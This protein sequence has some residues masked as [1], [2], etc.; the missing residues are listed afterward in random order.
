MTAQLQ[1]GPH[2]VLSGRKYDVVRTLSHRQGRTII[3]VQNSARRFPTVLKAVPV[4][5]IGEESARCEPR[6]QA[7]CAHP[8]VVSVFDDVLFRFHMF[9]EM[10]YASSGSLFDVITKRFVSVVEAVDYLKQILC[11]LGAMHERGI[12]HR[13]VGVENMMVFGS[14]VKLSDFGNALNLGS[15]KMVSDYVYAP[16]APP[17][18]TGHGG[19]GPSSD[20]YSV[21]LALLRMVNNQVEFHTRM[22]E[23][24]NQM[25]GE[26]SRGSVEDFIPVNPYVPEVIRSIIRRALSANP[27]DRYRTAAEMRDDL[28]RVRPLRNWRL[29]GKDRWQCV[30]GGR[31]ETIEILPGLVSVIRSTLGGKS[32]ELVFANSAKARVHLNTVVSKTTLR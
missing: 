2:L 15:G 20:V 10:E 28:E 4:V 31:P 26:N 13:D 17:E 6:V 16:Y 22:T 8:N 1:Y 19:F 18:V 11:A 23:V 7:F 14:T 9:I 29:T 21:G 30:S 24:R 32:N 12:V 5:P 27:A 25:Q 3:L